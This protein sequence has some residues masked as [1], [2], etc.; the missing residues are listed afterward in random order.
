[1][2]NNQN[3]SDRLVFVDEPFYCRGQDII[4][5][6]TLLTVYKTAKIEVEKLSS[7]ITGRTRSK[8]KHIV[9]ITTIHCSVVVIVYVFCF[10]TSPV[11]IS[12]SSLFFSAVN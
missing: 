8:P 1:M 5:S 2:M 12:K 10:F 4:L 9:Q 7:K 6:P 11:N 3:S